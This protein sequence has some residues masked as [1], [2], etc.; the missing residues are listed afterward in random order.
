MVVPH[1]DM[2]QDFNKE[3]LHLSKMIFYLII[4]ALQCYSYVYPQMAM[5]QTWYI[6]TNTS[7]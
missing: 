1:S 2:Y 4:T 7:M 6:I 3:I 5:G